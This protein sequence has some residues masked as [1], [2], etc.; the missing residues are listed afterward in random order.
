[1]QQLTNFASNLSAAIVEIEEQR[2]RRVPWRPV[3]H[4]D[5][6]TPSERFMAFLDEDMGFVD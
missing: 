4:Q 2:S 5:G 3:N 1:M 6:M